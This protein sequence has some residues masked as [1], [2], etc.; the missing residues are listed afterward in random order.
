MTTS[1][2]RHQ[3]SFQPIGGP[4]AILSFGGLR[5]IIDPTF[6]EPQ[7]YTGHEGTVGLKGVIRTEGPA[8]GAHELGTI[9]VALVSHDHHIDNLDTSGR[10]LLKDVT[11]VYTTDLG[12]ERL[13]G[14]AVGLEDYK[15]AQLPLPDGGT[16]TITGVPAQHGPDGVWQA[17]GPVTGFVLSGDIPT[18][19]VSGDNSSVDIVKGIAERFPDIELAVLFVGGAGFEELADGVYITLSNERALQVANILTKATIVPVHNDSWKHFREDA[20]DLLG[21]FQRAG[22]TDRLHIVERGAHVQVAG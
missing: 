12:A 7:D 4:T 2:T 13:G 5:V 17:I 9:D 16:V 19:Y 22:A 14:G 3:I 11:H 8:V 20:D 10:E 18:T 15:T 6:D 21:V 1:T